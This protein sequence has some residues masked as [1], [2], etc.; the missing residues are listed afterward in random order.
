MRRQ[1]VVGEH[2]ADESM[3]LAD[4]R[5]LVARRRRLLQH[6]HDMM[7]DDVGDLKLDVTNCYSRTVML[8]DVG[9]L[10]TVT[11]PMV[12][13]KATIRWS[14]F[15]CRNPQWPSGIAILDKQTRPN[16]SFLLN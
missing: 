4:D 5:R 13:V 14:L 6:R 12:S 3:R 8:R 15:V 16:S 7:C 2:V 11:D 1:R 9:E 10:M